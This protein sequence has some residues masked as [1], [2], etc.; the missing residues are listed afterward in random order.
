MRPT[1]LPTFSFISGIS[2]GKIVAFLNSSLIVF[3]CCSGVSAIFGG[4]AFVSDNEGFGMVVGKNGGGVLVV[5]AVSSFL[6]VDKNSV[7]FIVLGVGI[8]PLMLKVNV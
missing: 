3:S 2:C 8:Q 4:N 5:L 6:V 7:T 1:N